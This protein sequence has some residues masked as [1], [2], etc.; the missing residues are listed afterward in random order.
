MYAG[1]SVHRAHP[2]LQQG[3]PAQHALPVRG[4]GVGWPGRGCWCPPTRHLRLLP[5]LLLLFPQQSLQK[6]VIRQI[7][8]AHTYSSQ[9]SAPYC[10]FLTKQ[11]PA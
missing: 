6:E 1:Q 10:F 4:V 7:P 11:L 5:L 8:N 2:V 3:E 9:C